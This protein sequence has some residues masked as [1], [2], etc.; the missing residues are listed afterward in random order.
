MSGVA[1]KSSCVSKITTKPACTAT[2]D[3]L[4]LVILTKEIGK[5]QLSRL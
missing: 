5:I 3:G 4:V 1:R 2:D